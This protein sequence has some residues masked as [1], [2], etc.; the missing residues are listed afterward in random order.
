MRI[1]VEAFCAFSSA[2]CFRLIR[3]VSEAAFRLL[4]RLAPKRSDWPMTAARLWI[5]SRSV[6]WARFWMRLGRRAAEADF[7]IDDPQL[8]AEQRGGRRSTRRRR[9]S[10]PPGSST[11]LR[12]R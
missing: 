6:R 8:P 12:G 4:T 7:A 2:F 1:L 11:R 5:S 10:T 3:R 9:A